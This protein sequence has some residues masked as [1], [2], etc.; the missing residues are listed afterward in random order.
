MLGTSA[1]SALS[2]TRFFHFVWRVDERGASGINHD[3][4]IRQR[5]QDREAEFLENGAVYVMRTEGFLAAR[6]RFFGKTAI[7]EMDARKSLEIDELDD[8]AMA[9][10]LL[11]QRAA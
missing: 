2:A 6:H 4:R 8:F 7:Y 9:E 3:K 10:A 11:R 1:D 5:R